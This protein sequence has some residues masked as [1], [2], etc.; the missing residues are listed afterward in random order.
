MLQVLKKKELLQV[1]STNYIG[2]LGYIFQERPFVVPITYF[3]CKENHSIIG[4]SE[5]GQKTMAMRKN[6]LVSMEV[7]EIESVSNWRSV[8]VHGTYNELEGVDAKYYLHDFSL[9]VK[10]VIR[11]K[12]FRK[13]YFISEFSSKIH[14]DGIPVVFQIKIDEITGRK[15]KR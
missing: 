4:Y 8:L 9:G 7:A 13:L 2:Y 11:K 3:Y 15:R 10:N 1:L 6:N 12:E 14:G 5:S